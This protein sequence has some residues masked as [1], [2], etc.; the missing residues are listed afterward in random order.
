[1]NQE[2]TEALKKLVELADGMVCYLHA[3]QWQNLVS[4]GAND[5][6][7]VAYI[8][9]IGHSEGYGSPMRAVEE[10]EAKMK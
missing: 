7:Y 3:E 1:M 2:W 8:A 5:M 9:D 6:Q 10:L 4:K